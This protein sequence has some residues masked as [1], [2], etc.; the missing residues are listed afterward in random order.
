M[1]RSSFVLWWADERSSTC[2]LMIWIFT[3]R[4]HR[5]KLMSS[6]CFWQPYFFTYL[7]N[8]INDYVLPKPKRN[9]ACSLYIE[10][11]YNADKQCCV[12][13]Y[14]SESFFIS[15]NSH[16]H[17][18]RMK[19]FHL[20]NDCNYWTI[21]RWLKSNCK[22][23]C[24]DFFC[25]FKYTYNHKMIWKMCDWWYSFAKSSL[26]YTTKLHNVSKDICI[27]FKSF[28]ELSSNKIATS[29]LPL[30]HICFE[31]SNSSQQLCFE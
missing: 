5:F 26:K 25:E 28:V 16:N 1:M 17:K 6:M 4:I 10:H 15:N 9:T 20:M 30:Q 29:K 18:L 27:C 2:D 3:S 14:H 24:F 19:S 23:S 13:T 7:Q 31:S 8:F 12:F 21:E 22:R 11:S